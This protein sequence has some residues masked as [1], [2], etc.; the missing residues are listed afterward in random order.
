[1]MSRIIYQSL[2]KNT[3]NS[4]VKR[5][6]NKSTIYPVYPSHNHDKQEY[7]APN[8]QPYNTA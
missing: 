1:M 4:K 6:Q 7:T 8:P 2:N 3:T 5:N